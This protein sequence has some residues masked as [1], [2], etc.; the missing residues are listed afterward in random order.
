MRGGIL[1]SFFLLLSVHT[2]VTGR[3]MG[4][5]LPTMAASAAL[6]DEF[7][8]GDSALQLFGHARP[9]AQGDAWIVGGHKGRQ[10]HLEVG[11]AVLP[12]G[13]LHL[14]GGMPE[15]A[16]PPSTDGGLRACATCHAIET[17]VSLG[18]CKISQLFFC[19][20][21][22]CRK[23]HWLANKCVPCPLPQSLTVRDRM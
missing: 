20:G 16:G 23:Q 11:D 14:R 4:G 15:T 1:L 9:D 6:M 10:E 7:S 13:I 18:H 12:Q 21:K 8:V 22:E 3:W 5:S 2:A 17:Q 19:A